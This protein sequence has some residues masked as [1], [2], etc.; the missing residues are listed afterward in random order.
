MA[1]KAVGREDVST[2][3]NLRTTLLTRRQSLFPDG[4]H[5]RLHLVPTRGCRTTQCRS[6]SDHSSN[7]SLHCSARMV[8][9]GRGEHS[10]GFRGCEKSGGACRIPIVCILYW[11]RLL[12][13]YQLGALLRSQW[14]HYG[15]SI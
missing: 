7:T 14:N 4:V 9:G 15:F 2:H 12:V 5:H 1:N 13:F 6:P 11:F 8:L 10:R 3:R